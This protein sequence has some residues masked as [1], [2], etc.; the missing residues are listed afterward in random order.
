MT[1]HD[2]VE[3]V[4]YK[5]LYKNFRFDRTN[6]WYIHKSE[7]VLENETPKLLRDFEKQTDHL[8]LARRPDLAIINIKKETTK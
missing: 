2:W 5:E 3:K 1:R 8:I 6:N 4:I 7:T